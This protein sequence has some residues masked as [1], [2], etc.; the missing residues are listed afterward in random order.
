[1]KI[2]RF[3]SFFFCSCLFSAHIRTHCWKSGFLFCFLLLL[4]AYLIPG[5]RT[6]RC[7]WIIS[8]ALSIQSLYSNCDL[9]DIR[10]EIRNQHKL[11][12]TRVAISM[13]GKSR[14]R[15]HHQFKSRSW[16]KIR[17]RFGLNCVK[18]R[19]G[20]C[21]CLSVCLS[22]PDDFA[23]VL[24]R[25][26]SI[27]ISNCLLVSCDFWIYRFGFSGSSRNFHVPE[28][29]REWNLNQMSLFDFESSIKILR[30][31]ATN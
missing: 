15:E 11:V 5:T 9:Q 24:F 6:L 13:R 27:C 28:R 12:Y 14:I 18:G 30:N 8:N 17:L 20:V 3:L 29:E 22:A 19:S 10:Q 1:M 21:L 23:N 4:F 31:E 7:R 25:A 26:Y 16:K 2:F